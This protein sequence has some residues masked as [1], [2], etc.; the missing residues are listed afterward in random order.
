MTRSE[1]IE[2]GEFS[3]EATRKLYDQA[4]IEMFQRV[5]KPNTKVLPFTKDELVQACQDLAI[6]INNVPDIPYHYRT[7]RSD[8]PDEI[9]DTGNWVIEGAGKGKYTFVKLERE[10]YIQI[11]E[12]LY[13]T[14]VPE[15]TPDV[16]LKYGSVDEQ[17]LLTRIRYNRLVDTFLS[18]TAYHLQG[19]VRSSV[20]DIGQVEIDD[21][22]VGVDTDG[23]WYVIPVEAKS[24]G[25]QER[26]GVIQVRQMILF[27]KQ[28]YGDLILRPVGIKPLDDG[29]YVFLEFDDKA[30]L[31][32]ISVK[33]YARYRLIR[34]DKQDKSGDY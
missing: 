30:D 7:G 1:V 13:I 2:N 29:S 23:R 27:A 8:L 25:H 18:L 24:V 22:Y 21:L 5:Y 20:Q 14:E 17:G 26:L 34:D 10:P 15:A 6:V 4:I 16:V 12:D 32:T 9:L 11:P 31:E 3:V 33:R 19:H 28:Y